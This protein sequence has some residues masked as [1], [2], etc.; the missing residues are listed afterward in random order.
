MNTLNN[1]SA[2]NKKY[3]QFNIATLCMENNCCCCCCSS[4]HAQNYIDDHIPR[5]KSL[6]R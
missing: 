4:F 3:T 2:T 6:Q 5:V 1:L